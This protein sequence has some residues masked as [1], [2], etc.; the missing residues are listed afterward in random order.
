[1]AEAPDEEA[2]GFKTLYGLL[3]H[4]HLRGVAEPEVLHS[5]WNDAKRALSQANLNGAALKGTLMS[6][7]NHGYFLGGKNHLHKN[8]KS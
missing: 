7:L 5:K 2:I 4:S 8:K 3:Y 1:M 6:N